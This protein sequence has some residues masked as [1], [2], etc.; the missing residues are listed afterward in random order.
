MALP[1][2]AVLEPAV[3]NQARAAV[4]GP[5]RATFE[6]IETSA[7][8][9]AIQRSDEDPTRYVADHRISRVGAMDAV[10]LQNFPNWQDYIRRWS[11]TLHL[12]R[13]VGSIVA[14]TL[15][16][17]DLIVQY[18]QDNG[19]WDNVDQAWTTA[20]FSNYESER[21]TTQELLRMHAWFYETVGDMYQVLRDGPTGVEWMLYSA[22][23]VRFNR[24][25]A[26]VLDLPNGSERSGTAFTVPRTQIRRFW[27]PDEEWQGWATSPMAAVVNDLHLYESL[28][29]YYRNT[30]DSAV[31]MNGVLWVPG[32]AVRQMA[33]GSGDEPDMSVGPSASQGAISG[34]ILRDYYQAAARRLANTDTIASVAPFVMHWNNEWKPPEYVKIGQG[35]DPNGIEYLQEARGNFARGVN[36][37]GALVESGGTAAGSNHWNAWLVQEDYFKTIAPIEE[38]MCRDLTRTFLWYAL[39]MLGVGDFKRYRVWYDPAPVIVRPDQGANALALAKLGILNFEKVLETFGFDSSDLMPPDEI[40]KLLRVLAAGRTQPGTSGAPGALGGGGTGPGANG[41]PVGPGNVRRGPPALPAGT[42]AAQGSVTVN[43]NGDRMSLMDAIRTAAPPPALPAAAARADRA[44][45]AV[46]RS[47]RDA[48]REIRAAAETAFR[49]AI[50]RANVKVLNRAATRGKSTAVRNAAAA[51]IERLRNDPGPLPGRALRPHL[52]AVGIKEEEL[53]RD[54]FG[55]TFTAQVAQILQRHADQTRTILDDNG[56]DDV[57]TGSSDSHIADATAFLSAA[58]LA[59]AIG[60]TADGHP[61]TPAVGETS[62]NVPASYARGALAIADG[63]A[64]HVPAERPDMLPDVVF[65]PDEDLTQRI[66]EAVGADPEVDGEPAV[67]YTWNWGFYG[68]PLTPFEPHQ[69]LGASE[70]TT[71][72]IENDPAL[73]NGDSFPEGDF[74]Q[75]G[76]HDGCSGEW[77]PTIEARYAQEPSQTIQPGRSIPGLGANPEAVARAVYPVVTTAEQR[78]AD[79]NAGA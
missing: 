4:A 48:G 56:F 66:A 73:A 72:D 1:P 62:G 55:T 38:R 54:S 19:D 31:A 63:A 42:P 79:L 17:C 53:F 52:A 8:V 13:F 29:R 60:R 41:L 49:S 70:F 18:L 57:D 15:S 36:I 58:L 20:L 34:S 51:A 71:T 12:V 27:T 14:D 3:L 23:A 33:G 26:L 10:Y 44:L 64:G 21:H 5:P 45:A 68:D 16:R 69:D 32:E 9:A 77:V 7:R 74:Y 43:V 30:A 22:N 6:P 28:T 50:E 25:T 67:S 11:H 40:T 76:D 75:P 47:R 61:L 59:L 24:D 2:P 78:A 35:L 37:P 39:R 65:V 46:Y